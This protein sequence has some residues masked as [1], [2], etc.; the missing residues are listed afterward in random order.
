MINQ[1]LQQL[2]KRAGNLPAQVRSLGPKIQDQATLERV[3]KAKLYI[4]ELRNEVRKVFE[5]MKKKAYAAYKEILDQYK[6]VE[7]P[8][9]E[10]EK[11]CD[12]LLAEWFAEQRRIREEAER[13]RLEAIRKQKEEEERKLREALEA[14]NAGKK[15]EAEKIINQVIEAKPPEVKTPEKPKLK[16]VYS[17]IDYDFEIID[18]TKI[19]REYMIPDETLIRKVIRASK[20]KVIIPGIKVIAKEIVVTRMEASR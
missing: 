4:R 13:K 12:R 19:P 7:A 5:P 10:A 3:N 9:I 17:R 20:G 18:V 14:E 16:G 11:Y 6:K 2:E 15:E 1:E 8:I